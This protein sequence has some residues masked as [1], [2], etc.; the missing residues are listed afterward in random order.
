M[1]LH[2]LSS[3]DLRSVGSHWH[4]LNMEGTLRAFSDPWVALHKGRVHFP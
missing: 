4:I 3:T 1:A 2:E